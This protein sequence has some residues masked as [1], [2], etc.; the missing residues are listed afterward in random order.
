MSSY[1]FLF[2][3][4]TSHSL[5]LSEAL[6]EALEKNLGHQAAR[7]DALYSEA[8]LDSSTAGYLPTVTAT[9]GLGRNWLDTR[10][11]R[12][13]NVIQVQSNAQSSSANAG[14]N[15]NWTL[16]QGWSGPLAA[17]RLR[18]QR[19]QAR[20]SEGKSREDLLR[21][22]ALAYAD[23]AR[24]IRLRHALDT[25][26]IISGER[27]RILE[28]SFTAGGASRSEMLSARVDLNAD[29]AAALR[30]D[31]TL[32][33]ARILLGTVLGREKPVTEDVDTLF[34]PADSLDLNP[35]LSGLE[36]N[37]PELRLAAGSV[38]LAETAVRQRASAWFP[39]LDALAGYNLGWTQSDAGLVLENRT[40]G[41]S[42]G[43]QLNFNLFT[44]EFPWQ[45]YRRARIAVTSAD[46]RRRDLLSAAE[47][48]VRQMHAEFRASDS[49]LILER[50]GLGYARE[51]LDL[52]FARWR[53]GLISYLEARRAQEQYLGA[54]TRSEN[55]AFDS[56]RARLDLL[57]AAGRM[58]TLLE[59][60][61]A[62]R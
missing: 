61:A 58:E 13:G 33:S 55:T 53:S 26:A 2:L 7:N 14:V 46:L 41:P 12:T 52:T 24:Q 5:S 1:W 25:V 3:A 8:A 44:G 35:L 50:Q 37:R 17:R 4:S 28:R 54:M 36:N 32:Q 10:Q 43:L 16:F 11:E 31:A 56:F 34:F 51:N 59:S 21:G 20:A 22:T 47:S 38:A 30:Q 29:R 57:R 23:L 45:S 6:R 19:D 42:L 18:L 40:L 60:P 39:K 48:E 9:G 15:M 62:G 49:A 27:A